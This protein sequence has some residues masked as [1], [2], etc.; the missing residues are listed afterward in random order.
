MS[1]ITNKM[2]PL[3]LIL[4]RTKL[5]S[6]HSLSS[7]YTS[8]LPDCQL[9]GLGKSES[10]EVMKKDLDVSIYH[11]MQYSM[12]DATFN[13]YRTEINRFLNWAWLVA[14]KSI[15]DMR[16]H[17]IV[18]YIDFCIFPSDVWQSDQTDYAFVDGEDGQLVQNPKWRPFLTSNQSNAQSTIEAV[19]TRL[20]TFYQTLLLDEHVSHNPVKT[21]RQKN[22]Y[23]RK[24]KSVA[25]FKVLTPDQIDACIAVCDERSDNAE[26][27]KEF[28]SAERDRFAIILGL[29][30]YLRVSE[31]VH[32][33]GHKPSH[34]H[35]FRDID[36]HW[37]FRTVGKGNQERIIA[38][39]DEVL[40]AF[41]RYRTVHDLSE[42]PSRNETTPLFVSIGNGAWDSVRDCFV[43]RIPLTDTLI[44]WKSFKRV[45][46][47]ARAKMM[48]NGN[49]DDALELLSASCH[50]LRHTGISNDVKSRSIEHVRDDAGHQSVETTWSY[51]QSVNRDRA[52]S[53]K[54][55]PPR[56]DS[57]R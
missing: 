57:D 12:S 44:M 4:P 22:T 9:D 56:D 3:P 36:N 10:V 25:N 27:S 24:R 49:G 20:S 2:V 16:N 8:L 48:A 14:R 40:E 43:K 54:S 42:L 55:P 35:F 31:M 51:V 52:L 7:D 28:I 26:T 5:L 37:W 21:I 34:S 23:K 17:D 33:E 39:S 47:D 11:L 38:V 50:W 15:S 53:K 46:A 1:R 13:F 45:F 19:F 41:K 32:T 29:G 6:S 18:E 30:L